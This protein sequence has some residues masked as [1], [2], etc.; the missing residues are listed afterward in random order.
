VFCTVTREIAISGLVF[1]LLQFIGSFS[2][3]FA[4]PVQKQEDVGWLFFFSITYF[5]TVNQAAALGVDLCK[6]GPK[7][8]VFFLLEKGGGLQC[9]IPLTLPAHIL[10]LCYT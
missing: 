1:K 3:N 8:H 6:I 5:W 4:N 7:Y 10:R 2:K 9:N